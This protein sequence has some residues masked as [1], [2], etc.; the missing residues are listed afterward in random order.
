MRIVA[1]NIRAGGGFRG[2]A[3]GAQLRRFRPDVAAL[4]EFRAT[5]PSAALALTLAA[6]GL[7]HQIHHRRSARTRC[8]PAPARLEVSPRPDRGAPG[9]GRAGSLAPCA[10]RSAGT[11]RVGR[12]ARAEPGDRS[13]VALPRLGVVHRRDLAGRSRRPGQRHELGKTGDRRGI[14]R[15]QPARGRLDRRPRAGGLARC[16]PPRPRP[17][18]T[19]GTRPMG[20]T[21]SGSI[22]PS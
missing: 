7:G 18:T 1:W 5:P 11:V 21:A 12:H 10:G 13:K 16:V 2:L 22:K 6:L 8:Q 17:A 19:R 15:L 4:C 20:A 9:T 14:A 3:L